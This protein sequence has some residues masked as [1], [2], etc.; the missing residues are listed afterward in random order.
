MAQAVMTDTRRRD[1]LHYWATRC[2][3]LHVKDADATLCRPLLKPLQV[4][5]IRPG[6]NCGS[7]AGLGSAKEC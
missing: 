3:R 7:E 2:H 5:I 4:D 6:I 1:A